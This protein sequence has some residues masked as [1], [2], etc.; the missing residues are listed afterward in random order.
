MI[1][2]HKDNY[3]NNLYLCIF[4]ICD[5]DMAHIQAVFTVKEEKKNQQKILKT[6]RGN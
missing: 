5:K 1:S 3:K 2:D 4:I 6:L